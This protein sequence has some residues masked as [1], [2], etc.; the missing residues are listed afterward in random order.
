MGDSLA[1]LNDK[2]R[3]A[4]LET[5]GP[6][7]ILAG[8]GSGKTRVLTHRIAYLIAEKGV[9]PWNI[10]AITFTN[11]AAGEMR[12]RV[13]A[14]VGMGSESIWVATFHSS[15][16]RILRRFADRLG[17]DTSFTIYDTDDQKS[18]MKEVCK[19]LQIDTKQLKER[20]ILNAIS[21]AKNEL[22]DEVKFAE[23]T[24]GD[25]T[26]QRISNAYTEYQNRLRKNNAMDFD[27]LILN[28][29][30]LFRSNPDVLALYTERFHYV[31]VDEYQDTNT[32]QFKLVELLSGGRRNLCVVG[33]DDQSI[34]RFRGANI[35]NILDFERVYPDATVIRLEQNYRSTQNILDAA[36][37]VIANNVGRKEKSLW[38]QEDAGRL[39]HYRPFDT[40]PQ[41]A[42]YI[43]DEIRH[44]VKKEGRT[45]GDFAILYRTNAQSRLLEEYLVREGIPYQVV[46]GVNFY[47]RKEIKDLLAYLK[48]I[49][50]G[51]DDLA[52]KRILNVPKRSIGQTT[53]GKIEQY[54]IDHELGFYEALFLA[55]QIPSLGKAAEKIHNFTTMIQA[56]R[57]KTEFYSL[58]ELLEDIMDTISYEDYLHDDADSE[59]EYEGRIENIDELISKL[60]DFE[61]NRENADLSAFLE[62][63]ALV[64]DIDSVEEDPDRVLLMTIHGAKGLEFS[65]VFLAGMEDGVFPGYMTISGGDREEMEEERRLAYVA[66]TRA[67]EE[68]T[69]SC[70]KARMLR[71][72]TQYNPVSRFVR[73][74]PPQLMDNRIPKSRNPFADEQEDTLPFDR[75]FGDYPV[76]KESTKPSIFKTPYSTPGG[77]TLPKARPF[78]LPKPAVT[79]VKAKP[80]LAKADAGAKQTSAAGAGFASIKYGVGDQVRHQKFGIGVV[81]A[82]EPGPRDTKVT[83]DFEEYGTKIMYAAFAKLEKTQ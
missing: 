29:V 63:V 23:M 70:A 75:P 57:A 17:Y 55:D 10:M 74:I 45:Y 13:D 24:Y 54:A 3:E 18:V 60:V 6:L 59:E 49:D 51:R 27:D 65:H 40:A 69:I 2:Q 14:L 53:I 20:T 67:R 58:S 19:Y 16:A 46:G 12:N 39:I 44:E 77:R 15:C 21:G 38:T 50:N 62:E 26:Q 32:A 52:V 82:M 80:F 8:A 33:D 1:S 28:T 5:E 68:L 22:I 34:Y 35:R 78:A 11:K 4:V 83:V 56:F 72:N 79:P 25:F 66:I 37:G 30:E 9:N 47:S 61:Q 41:E 76:R 43:A 64:A 48:T 71:G 7:L 36:N 31:H 42:E 81:K 73:E